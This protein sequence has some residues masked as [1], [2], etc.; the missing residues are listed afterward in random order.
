[1]TKKPTTKL[2]DALSARIHFGE[3]MDQAEKENLRFLVSKRGKPKI[4]ILGARDY[5]ENV[6]KQPEIL[7]KVQLSGK[8][9]NKMP[10]DEIGREV[11]TY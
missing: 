5:F 1:M 2:I 9:E 11:K 3:L 7:T 10:A 4:V 8:K 6:E